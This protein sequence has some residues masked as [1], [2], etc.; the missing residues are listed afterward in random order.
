MSNLVEYKKY[1]LDAEKASTIESSFT[2]KIEE[3]K[4][5]EKVYKEIINKEISKELASEAS[6]LRKKLVKVR[7]GIARI[8]KTEKAYFFQAGKFVDALKNKLTEPVVQ[9]EEK[10]SEIENYYENLE[11]ERLKKLQE[12]RAKALSDYVQ[13]SYERTL[14]SMD[15]DVWNAYFNAKKQAYEDRIEAEKEAERQRLENE[16]LDKLENERKYLIAPY[17]QFVGDD[18]STDFR[19]MKDEKFNDL[20]ENLKKSKSEYDKKQEEIRKENERLRK[21]REAEEKKQAEL[22]AKRKAEE[23]KKEAEHQAQLKKEREQREALE[24]AEKQRKEAE[25]K[26]KAEAKRKAKELAK[27]PIKKQ[28]TLWVN[29]FELP[30]TRTEHDKVNEIEVKFNNFKKWAKSQINEI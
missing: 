11:K 5:F 13:D 25:A 18:A 12:D 2:P 14:W 29:S 28:L 30:Q 9:M 20:L 6:D 27:A 10:L 3:R 16:R 4:G 17:L 24:R 26:A 19:N 7:T 23:A 22:E 8:H 15:E 21:E 1:D